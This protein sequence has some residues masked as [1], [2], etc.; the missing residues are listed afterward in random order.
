[1]DCGHNGGLCGAVPG[2]T[3]LVNTERGAVSARASSVPDEGVH[4]H[5]IAGVYDGERIQLFVHGELVGEAAGNGPVT[6]GSGPVSL[7][8]LDGGA[9]RFPGSILHVRVSDVARS[10]AWIRAAAKN[11]LAPREFVQAD[12]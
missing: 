11:M 4:P 5:H 9:A 8:Q 6:A 3:F 10:A 12:A 2:P 1:M 7:G